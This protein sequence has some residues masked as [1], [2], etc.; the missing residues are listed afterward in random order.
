ME[1]TYSSKL[2]SIFVLVPFREAAHQGYSETKTQVGFDPVSSG[3]N[4]TGSLLP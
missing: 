4:L 1:F 3:L 2:D